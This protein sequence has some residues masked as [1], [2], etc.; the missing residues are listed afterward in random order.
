[1][2]RCQ[3]VS[4]RNKNDEKG[5]AETQQEVHGWACDGCGRRPV[6]HSVVLQELLGGEKRLRRAFRLA[7]TQKR[8][9]TIFAVRFIDI[10]SM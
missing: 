5:E 3:D 1:M 10:L 9:A 6:M 7:A 8:L 2:D 4:L